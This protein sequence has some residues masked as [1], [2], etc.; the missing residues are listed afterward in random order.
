MKVLIV[1]NYNP[2]Y[3]SSFVVEQVDF[4]RKLGVEFKYYA[5]VGKGV[6]EYLKNLPA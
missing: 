4:I 6:T 1:V 5:V 2:G 3:F